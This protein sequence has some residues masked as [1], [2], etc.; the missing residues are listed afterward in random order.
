M[1]LA[2]LFIIK[3]V[4]QTNIYK[5]ISMKHGHN[6]RK[7]ARQHQALRSKILKT[8]A[9]I[10]FIKTCKRE[11]LTPTFSRIK[12]SIHNS[13]KLK[14]KISNLVMDAE[15]NNLHNKRRKTLKQLKKV[16]STLRR[17]LGTI[18]FCTLI[19]LTSFII[20][21]QRVAINKRHA[22]KLSKLR[23][24]KPTIR[25]I[26]R[27][28]GAVHNF[29]SVTLTD[30]QLEALSYGLD[31][32]IPT[33]TNKV[34]I[35]TRYEEL[36]QKLS[37]NNSQISEDDK[38]ALKTSVLSNYLNYCKIEVPYKHEQSIKELRRNPNIAILKQDK[39]RGTVILDKDVYIDKCSSMLDSNQFSVC[40]TDPTKQLEGKVQR[41]VRKIKAHLTDSEYRK[42]YPSGSC[43]GR[44]YGNAKIHKLKTNDNVN[45]LPLRPIISNI[46]TATYHLAKY[47]AKLLAPLATSSYTV[48][49]TDEF[50]TKIR[51]MSIPDNYQL[52][53]FDVISLFTKV[54]LDFTIDIALRRIYKDN[55]ITTSIEQNDL[56]NMLIMCTKNVHFTFN[57]TIYIQN[58]GVAMG[59]PLG[60]VLAGICMVELEN[61]IIPKLQD[62]MIPWMRFV[63]DTITAIATNSVNHVITELNSF[64]SN[65]Q[66]TY[67]IEQNNSI[68]FLDVKL[69]RNREKLDTTVYRKPTNSDIYLNWNSFAPK[70]WRCGTLKTL[71]LRAYKI[72]STAKLRNDEIK[73]IK[74]VFRE[75]NDYPIGVIQEIARKLENGII[76]D[77][78]P[79]DER[80]EIHLLSLP[81]RGKK[82][83][84]LAGALKRVVRD[85]FSNVAVRVVFSGTKLASKFS[86]KDP[87]LKKHQHNVIY[88]ADCP[89]DNCNAQYIGETCRRLETRAEEHAKL[90]GKSNISKHSLE[91]GHPVA[92]FKNF[93][94]LSKQHN[95][96]T[97]S[98]KITEA[99]YIKQQRPSL[100]IQTASVPLYLF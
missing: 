22:K 20:K 25:N 13:W 100:N 16:N 98:R 90:D 34:E 27:Q 60:P 94:I 73:H 14:K 64:H 74:Q 72:C 58:D 78:I 23:N 43:P 18:Y 85:T 68:S 75:K 71:L 1:L 88:R 36:Y 54:P 55:D 17:T 49:S 15:L 4:A 7:M 80:Q 37:R 41:A 38:L 97:V 40:T 28:A 59:S 96:N 77:T 83:E 21:R 29:A 5:H 8:A 12:L 44:F 39:G 32:H 61:K 31:Q 91:T 63:D 19:Y 2:I 10:I 42:L 52:V 56:K 51:E 45:N 9:D 26:T 65:I 48:K 79:E 99:L 82:G 67:E 92:N 6:I 3:L 69:I 11:N 46:G 30:R 53:S 24:L 70:S 89:A 87:T 86:N 57:N 50:V 66:F 35:Q 47:L 84:K 62:C 93:T 95:S 81:Y 76:S 33:E